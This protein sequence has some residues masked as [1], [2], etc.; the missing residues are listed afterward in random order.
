MKNIGASRGKQWELR[1]ER[2]HGL[3]VLHQRYSSPTFILIAEL[4][5]Y[6]SVALHYINAHIHTQVKENVKLSYLGKGVHL[7]GVCKQDTACVWVTV[8][9]LYNQPLLSV[10]AEK[11]LVSCG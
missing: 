11:D 2:P 9:V 7:L 6:M 5:T 10:C 1:L 4:L 8:C 3:F